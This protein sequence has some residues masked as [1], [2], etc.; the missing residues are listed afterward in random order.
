MQLSLT[1]NY[2]R[3]AITFTLVILI[4]GVYSEADADQYTC[5]ESNRLVAQAGFQ[6]KDAYLSV[7]PEKVIVDPSLKRI[8]FGS[9]Y[10]KGYRGTEVSFSVR[11]WSD[12]YSVKFDKTKKI[13]KLTFF[14][15][16]GKGL[17]TPTVTYS[18]C[19]GK[20]TQN[21]NAAKVNK[22]QVAANQ[23]QSGYKERCNLTKFQIKLLQQYL[24]QLGLYRYEVDGKVGNGTLAA[25]E[26]VRRLI[27][28]NTNI[29]RCVTAEEITLI[30]R[31]IAK[32]QCKQ[33]LSDKCK[34]VVAVRETSKSCKDDPSKC[35]VLELCERGSVIKNGKYSWRTDN[36]GKKYADAAKKVGI[37]CNVESIN[38]EQTFP[39]S[40][41]TGFYVSNDGF[42]VTNQHVI[43]G[44][45]EV[46]VHNSGDIASAKLVGQ[47]KINDL[48]LLKTKRKAEAVFK[49]ASENPYLLQDIVAAGFPFGESISSSIKVTKGVVSSLSGL[50]NNSGQIQIDA[51]LQPGN[52]GGPIIDSH[53][54]VVGVAVAKL[55]VEKSF[56][57]F[58]AIPENVN[59]GIKLS[60][61]KTF[62]DDHSVNYKIGDD[63]EIKNSDLGK[64]ATDAT[65]LL[66]CWMTEARYEDM[67]NKKAMFTQQQKK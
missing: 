65:V 23:K 20:R 53:G 8:S 47:D 6:N 54:N 41:G 16:N 3:A 37:S 22:P 5:T 10:L 58:G 56:E 34:G 4:F 9:G 2:L 26:K 15:T 62:L 39:V 64:L 51:A 32:N 67:Q 24:S 42:V 49:L 60:S 45:N 17:G 36:Y 19:V 30:A 25:I 28:Q 21:N 1:F 48:A 43:N 13:L 38:T 52:S 12:R 44:C 7:F 40:N 66:S 33:P 31:F 27:G 35:G 59:F 14:Y 57:R 46:Q 63:L 29:S 61:L 55:D 11:R 18:R 50:G